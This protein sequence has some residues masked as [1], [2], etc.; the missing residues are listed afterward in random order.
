MLSQ[1]IRE[2]PDRAA[3]AYLRALLAILCGYAVLGRGFAYLGFPPLFVGEIALLSGMAIFLRTNCLIG[4]AATLPAVMLVVLMAWVLWRTVPFVGPDGIQALRDSVVVT[5]GGFAFIVTALVLQDAS[6]IDT[7]LRYYSTFIKFF[8]PVI[9]ALYLFQR[10]F[11]KYI[12]LVPGTDIP[13][14][15]LKAGGPAVHL[16]GA[17]VFALAGFRPLSALWSF[18]AFASL[19]IIASVS[20][21]PMLAGFLPILLAAVLLSRLRQ[22]GR[23][24]LLGLLIFAAVY[25]VEPVFYTYTTPEFGDLRPISTRQIVQNVLGTFGRGDAQGQGTKEWRYE[26]WDAIAGD[27]LY[28][29]HFWTGRGFGV[30]LA[31]EFGFEN[32]TD[33]AHPARDPHNVVMTMLGR[34]G[35]PGAALWL[36]FAA[37]WLGLMQQMAGA[38]RRRGQH[39]WAGL[40]V[41][42][43]CYALALIINAFFDPSLEGPMQG[44]WFWCLVGL[45]NGAAGVYRYRTLGFPAAPRSPERPR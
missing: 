8:V 32:S 44:V 26:F 6:R 40:F 29:A 34:A 43:M 23:F 20:R 12:P 19:A 28:G 42:L 10:Y 25:V 16:S 18:T 9:A 7:M 38:A 5:Y 13:F 31:T 33:P 1:T 11:G 41:F 2:T 3:D 30:N 35:V 37:A 4:A 39:E 36:I 17:I 24:C 14:L 22:L 27:T 45:G 15:D 21:G